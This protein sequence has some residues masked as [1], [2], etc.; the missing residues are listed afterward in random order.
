MNTNNTLPNGYTS[1]PAMLDDLGI[2]TDFL[3]LFAMHHAGVEDTM[4][5]EMRNEW[6]SPGTVLENDFRLVF[7]PD[8]RMVGYAEVWDA[9]DPP[10]KPWVWVAV[11][12]QYEDCGITKYLF[13]WAEE[14]A[15][16]A[17]PRVE[18][19]VRVAM[20]TGY[21][22]TAVSMLDKLKAYGFE[23]TRHYFR[24]QIDMDS[25]PPEP[26]W[27]QG[28]R[29]K[30]FVFEEDMEAVYAADNEAFSDHY[31]H[32]ER[33]PEQGLEDF[34][35]NIVKNDSHDPSLWF[36][37]MDGDE[38]AGI[39]LC[40][41]WASD[42]PDCGYISHL[43]VRKPWRKRGLGLALLRH[44][45]SEFY[46]RGYPR[47]AL[48]VDAQN[49]TGALRLYEKAG[50]YVKRSFDNFQKELRPGRDISVKNIE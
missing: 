30:P 42:D 34:I 23:V 45:F 16:Q 43:A 24:M 36:L 28:I 17:V 33:D 50:M 22:S 32:V 5:E 35:H 4:L 37:A 11:H 19:G 6:T 48:G 2:T 12:P 31:G 41:K 13:H 20:L 9:L 10:V 14:R 46:R 49:L 44:T 40:N 15:R 47:V 38:I 3:N 27:P 26:V 7:G 18:D 8:G 29:L 39:S 25:P 21:Y 1:R